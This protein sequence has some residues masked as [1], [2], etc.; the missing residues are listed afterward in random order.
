M[1]GAA[2]DAVKQRMGAATLDALTH[3]FPM[4]VMTPGSDIAHFYA[5]YGVE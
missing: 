4:P 3:S 2:G 5:F 1:V